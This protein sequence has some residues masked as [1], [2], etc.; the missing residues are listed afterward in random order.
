[1]LTEDLARDLVYVHS[2]L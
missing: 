1:M 2:I